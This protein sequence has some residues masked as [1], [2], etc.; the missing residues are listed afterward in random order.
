MARFYI[1]YKSAIGLTNLRRG[2]AILYYT[3]AE[4]LKMRRKYRAVFACRSLVETIVGRAVAFA[5]HA[6]AFVVAQLLQV[7]TKR[8][9]CNCHVVQ[10][11]KP[12]PK[13]Y[14]RNS[15][16]LS[17]SP[18]PLFFMSSPI[19]FHNI[20]YVFHIHYFRLERGCPHIVPHFAAPTGSRCH[21]V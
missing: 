18:L 15:L 14:T 7:G 3:C 13:P 20:T 5:A 17:P 1:Q 10:T 21:Q 11:G 6:A 19:N 12:I 2:L 9:C 16:L 8:S 4:K